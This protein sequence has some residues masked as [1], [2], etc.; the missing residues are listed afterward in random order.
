MS[1]LQVQAN[2]VTDSFGESVVWQGLFSSFVSQDK[3]KHKPRQKAIDACKDKQ[4]GD[5]C[6]FEKRRGTVTGVCKTRNE[7]LICKSKSRPKRKE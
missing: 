5:S 1:S 4:E 6:E 7:K 3:E 2:P